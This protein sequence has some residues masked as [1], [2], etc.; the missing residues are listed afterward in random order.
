CWSRSKSAIRV[1]WVWTR[2]IRIRVCRGRI[3][4]TGDGTADDGTRRDAGGDAAPTSPVISASVA[5]T[6]D[7]DVAVDVDAVVVAAVHVGTVEV[8]A[9][10]VGAAHVAAVHIS[11]AHVAAVH[12]SAAHVGATEVAPARCRLGSCRATAYV[13]DRP[14][15]YRQYY[16]QTGT[17]ETIERDP[18][19]HLCQLER[20]SYSVSTP[21]G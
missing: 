2:R 21:N 3:G 14:A 11:A 13:E 16:P 18:P 7:V 12:I 1:I 15:P 5:T 10:H 19:T 8:A 20:L 17:T 4:R 9:V 6:A